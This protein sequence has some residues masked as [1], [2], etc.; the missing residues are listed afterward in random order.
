MN[1]FR[2]MEAI[3]DFEG[4]DR[5]EV[6]TETGVQSAVW[7]TLSRNVTKKGKR[8]WGIASGS[9]GGKKAEKMGVV[10]ERV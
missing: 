9:R 3:C 8:E 1:D 2:N 4:R 10:Q 7:T 6:E 5:R